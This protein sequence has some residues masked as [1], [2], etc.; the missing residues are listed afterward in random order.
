MSA[1]D[2]KQSKSQIE[3]A[4][5]SDESIQNVHASLL[6]NSPD[7]QEGR[8][9]LPLILL[10]FVSV[11]IF[12]AAI[13]VV[14]NRGGFDPLAQDPRF[15]PRLAVAGKKAAVDPVAEGQKLFTTCAACHQ[16]T[17]TGV[18]GTFPPLA[19]SEW[20]NGSDER[21]IRILLSGLSGTVTVAGN[22]YNNAMPAFG[23][24]GFAWSDDKISYVLTFV[25]QAWGNKGTAITPER[26]TEIR[27]KVGQRKAWSEEE[28]KAL[29]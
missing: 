3:R 25:R 13:Y 7:L 18:P 6:T 24:G 22:T 21:V 23:P 20:V 11:M 1:P 14:R 27:N 15:D 4:G 9:K 8:S 5:A 28:L 16:P 26:V 12:I 17:G 19:G 10:G 2:P 29:P